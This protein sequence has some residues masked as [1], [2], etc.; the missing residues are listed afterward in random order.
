MKVEEVCIDMWWLGLALFLVCIIEVSQSKKTL[1]VVSSLT[2]FAQRDNLE[3]PANFSWFTI[4]A[5]CGYSW[6]DELNYCS[7]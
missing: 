2:L 6:F 7:L 3:N 1:F 4:F 5:I